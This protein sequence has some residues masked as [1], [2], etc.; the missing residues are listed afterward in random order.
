MGNR[1]HRLS[2][3]TTVVGRSETVDV[4][5]EEIFAARRHC[6]LYWDERLGCHLLTVWGINGVGVNEI[7]VY[8]GTESRPLSAG[9]ELRIGGASLWYEQVIESRSG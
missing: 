2:K 3:G 5:I 6:A 1:L 9:D 7:M 8:A 4:E